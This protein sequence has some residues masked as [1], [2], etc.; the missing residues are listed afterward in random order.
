LLRVIQEREVRRLGEN[1]QRHLEV[2]LVVATN[3]NLQD[4]VDARRFRRDLYFG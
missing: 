1:R 2:R 3:Q 4:D